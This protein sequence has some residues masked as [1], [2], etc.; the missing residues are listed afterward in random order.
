MSGWIASGDA[1]MPC[2]GLAD[3]PGNP[4]TC[5]YVPPAE[6]AA[7]SARYGFDTSIGMPRNFLL[8]QVIEAI[9]ERRALIRLE[10]P[11]PNYTDD[12]WDEIWRDLTWNDIPQHTPAAVL[13]RIRW[14]ITRKS[15][16]TARLTFEGSYIGRFCASVTSGYG[17]IKPLDTTDRLIQFARM[18]NAQE[19]PDVMGGIYGGSSFGF[20]VAPG[21]YAA[22]LAEGIA[23]MNGPPI[24]RARHINELMCAVNVCRNLFPAEGIST[25]LRIYGCDIEKETTSD[26]SEQ[27]FKDA[28]TRARAET[29]QYD[30]DENFDGY[31]FQYRVLRGIET[32]ARW[33]QLCESAMMVG[34]VRSY[35]PD[36]LAITSCYGKTYRNARSEF[37]PD[38]SIASQSN[39][40]TPEVK[41]EE[42]NDWYFIVLGAQDQAEP[43]AGWPATH[44]EEIEV[45]DVADRPTAAE[46]WNASEEGE[47]E[48]YPGHSAFYRWHLKLARLVPS[49]QYEGD[50]NFT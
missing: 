6:R 7:V 38:S 37:Y 45:F 2:Q 24:L 48:N 39:W 30:G 26:I 8:H 33:L 27:C 40:A 41:P 16:S 28:W 49:F 32:D 42:D 34:G 22:T 20:Y 10:I 23:G 31:E 18:V 12:E 9:N 44:I 17:N 15:A 47:E 29:F 35:D 46:M 21:V 5:G 19:G 1:R 25:A 11:H 36:T 43:F 14:F 50:Y 4:Q 13:D 3:A